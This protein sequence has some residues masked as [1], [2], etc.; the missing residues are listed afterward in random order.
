[1]RHCTADVIAGMA[2]DCVHLTA[3][4]L[5]M[6]AVWC[7]VCWWPARVVA[8]QLLKLARLIRHRHAVCHSAPRHPGR[9]SSYCWRAAGSCRGETAPPMGLKQ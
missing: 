3:R 5:E 4:S 2:D 7:P 8:A 1:M 9:G 6:T